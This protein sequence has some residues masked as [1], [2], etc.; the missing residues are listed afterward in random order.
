MKNDN[1]NPEE[2]CFILD[3]HRISGTLDEE[4]FQIA[5]NSVEENYKSVL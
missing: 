3:D 4:S 2:L 5:F 1:D